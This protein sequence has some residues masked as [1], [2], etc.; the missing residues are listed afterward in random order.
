MNAKESVLSIMKTIGSEIN[1]PAATDPQIYDESVYE[2]F[3]SA[4]SLALG[5]AYM[6]KKWD[7]NDLAGFYTKGLKQKLQIKKNI[8]TDPKLFLQSVFF[9]LQSKQRAFHVGEKHYD[10]GNDLYEAT[11]GKHLLYTC[12][13]WD[14]ARNLTEAQEKK[15]DRICR[16]LNLRPGQRLLDVGCGWGGLMRF[17]AMHYKVSCVGLS[18][19]KEQTLYGREWCQGLPVEFIIADY[20]D[21]TDAEG[22][23]HVSSIEMIEHVGQKNYRTYFEKIHELLKPGGT[24]MLQAIIS[25]KKKP[26]ADPW[27][28]K[29]IFPNGV[30]SSPYQIEKNTRGL[31]HYEDLKNIGPDYDPTLMAWW[32]NF[33]EAYPELVQKNPKYDERFYRMWKYYLQT[34]AALFRTEQLHDWQVLLKRTS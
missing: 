18:V 4:N 2:V 22:F 31:F 16:K 19:S 5:E 13:I 25:P 12:D 8:F 3:L 14:G 23:D 10:L 7:C 24:F 30:L 20:R 21:Y 34:C 28:D 1:G 32:E 17:A 6:D 33:E 11:L 27:L 15:M 26:I 9:N 29:Y